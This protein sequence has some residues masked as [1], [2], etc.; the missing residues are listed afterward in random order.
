MTAPV[1]PATSLAVRTVAIDDPGDLLAVVPDDAPVAWVRHGDGIVGWGEAARVD[2]GTGIDRFPRAQQRLDELFASMTVDDR[3]DAPGSGPVA[4]GSF[5]FDPRCSGSVLVVPAVTVGRRGGT[6]WMTTVGAVE[7]CLPPAQPLYAAGRVRYAGAS[8]PEVAWLDAVAE[9]AR[10]ITAGDLRKVVLARDLAVWSDE[11]LAVCVLARRL[12]DR[13]DDCFTFVCDG[14]V[15]ATPE[16]LVRRSGASVESVPLAGSAARGRDPD[17]DVRH[18]EAL[19]AS[20]KDRLE[21]ELAVA[22]VADVLTRYSGDLSVDGRPWLL[23]LANVMHLATRLSG[24]LTSTVPALSLAGALHPTAAVCGTPTV[25]AMAAIRRLEGMDRGRYSGP[26]G[27]VDSRGD[28]EWGVALRC[29]EVEGDRARLFAGAGIVG[30]SLPEAELEET[31]LKLR[32]MQSA[33]ES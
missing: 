8:I 15:G 18:G 23:R 24:T 9:A 14:L 30:A 28:G 26:V 12:A 7:A 10:V 20:T 3:V 17:D 4:F 1:R 5:T 21:H 19:L 22:S 33:L 11:R 31:R 6:A 25:E 29:A 16:L 27:W 2:V 13:F 32:A